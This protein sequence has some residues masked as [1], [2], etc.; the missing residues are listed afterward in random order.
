LPEPV[1]IGVLFVALH[2]P[3]QPVLACGSSLP[4]DLDPDVTASPLLIQRNV[5]DH[6]PNDLLAIS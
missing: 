2:A 1:L 3:L 5:L 6:Q 4:N